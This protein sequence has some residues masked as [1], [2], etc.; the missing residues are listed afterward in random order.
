MKKMLLVI[1]SILIV[2][3]SCTKESSTTTKEA[4]VGSIPAL[5]KDELAISQEE[6][7]DFSSPQFVD[8]IEVD[9]LPEDVVW[10]TSKPGVFGSKRAK[11]GGEMNLSLGQFPLTF[12]TVGPNSNSGFR[13]YKGSS[14][15]LVATNFETMEW[16]PQLA[17]HWGFSEDGKTAYYKLNEN[18][19]WDDGVKVTSKDY[20][21]LIEMMRDEDLV[22][23]WYNN[24]YKKHIVDL[25]AYGD[26]LI[27]VTSSIER[28]Q[29]DLLYNTNVAPRPSHF[30]NGEIKEGYPEEYNWKIEPTVGPYQIDSFVKGE[31]IVFKKVENWWGHVYDYNKY[32]YNVEKIN[33][34][35]ITGG[36]DI[37]KQYFLN[38]ETD[39]FGLIIPKEWADS[40][41]LEPFKKGYIDRYYSFYVPLTGITGINFNTTKGIFTDINVRTGMY[42]AINIDKMINTVL[43]GEYSRYH[44][45]GLAHVFAGV[46]FDDNSI[47]KPGFDPIK[48]AEYFSKAGY[49]KIGS[50]GI[51]VNSNGDR[52]SF[53]LLYG[54]Q[55][56]T[57]RIS[58]LKEEAKKAGVEMILNLQTEGSFQS[59]RDKEHEA[60][61]GGFS[62][63]P[64]PTYWQSFHSDNA[65]KQTNNIWNVS[66]E[67]LDELIIKSEK[68]KDL[69]E[70]AKIIIEI[71]RRVHDLA[72]VL[73]HYY[74]PYTRVGSWKWVRYPKWLNVKYNDSFSDP[75]YD[76]MHGYKGYNWIDEDIKKEVIQ[77]KIKGLTLE[78]KTYIDD[79]NKQ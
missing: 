2:T 28:S 72:L 61:W 13:A 71:Q 21:F 64:V 4:K 38:G 73:P 53:E 37:L 65:K 39:S 45:I 33:L 5:E 50:D 48:A 55:H 29:D 52:L 7:P 1:V 68:T 54:A 76:T 3:V 69:V 36:L 8:D 62:T 27:S 49:D 35:V 79:R 10:Y 30:Y 47:K 46:E 63:N 70:K 77:A 41:E 57:E 19:T 74:V 32:R 12:R 56:H 51:R 42:Y 17:T 24:F 23:P 31:S 26:Y 15:S 22:A 67:I 58:I 75:L 60:Y 11:S 9:G 43:R 34:K 20:L 78:M 40:T 14:A 25:K 6:M 59:A 18:V 44:N 16:M 66:D